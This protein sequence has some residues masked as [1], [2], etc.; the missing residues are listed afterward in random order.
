MFCRL[1]LKKARLDGYNRF[2]KSATRASL[3]NCTQAQ[4]TKTHEQIAVS[5][6]IYLFFIFN[7]TSLQAIPD[8]VHYIS[9][10][11][12]SVRVK[13]LKNSGHFLGLLFLLLH[14]AIRQKK[15]KD[16]RF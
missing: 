1:I 11:T 16:K 7:K 13:F 10:F 9:C 15:K 12:H 8:Y 2:Y 4:N 14:W 5:M 6:R 3:A